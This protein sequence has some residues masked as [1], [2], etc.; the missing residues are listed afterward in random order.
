MKYDF[1]PTAAI[2]L[3]KNIASELI[4]SASFCRE[5]NVA[6]GNPTMS[7]IAYTWNKNSSFKSITLSLSIT[8]IVVASKYFE[9]VKLTI[10]YNVDNIVV[11]ISVVD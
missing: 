3:F 6:T 8:D 7:A 1:K 10:Y 9:L 4:A 11:L 2:I 5:S